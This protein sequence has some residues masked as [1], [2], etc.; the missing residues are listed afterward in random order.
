MKVLVVEDVEAMRVQIKSLLRTFGLPKVTL[1]D[2][3]RKAAVALDEAEFNLI[4]CDWHLEGVNN[5]MDLLHHVRSVDKLKPIG[6]IMV[7]AEGTRE[8]V[9]EA[10][11]AG[12]DD[13]LLKPLTTAQIQDKVYG[14]LL[15]KKVL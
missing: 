6:F 5:G 7:T 2:S 12:V 10:V 9:I 14:V 3:F 15:R 4:L 11:K 1:C 8:M 13:Y